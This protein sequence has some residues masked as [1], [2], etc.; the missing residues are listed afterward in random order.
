MHRV[1]NCNW[2]TYVFSSLAA[3]LG[4]ATSAAGHSDIFLTN[5]GEQVAV[6]GANELESATPFFELD[7]QVFEAVLVTGF[8]LPL[9]DYGRGEPGVFALPAGSPDFPAG[10]SA[11]SGTAAVS[12]N[13]PSFTLNGHTDSLFYWDGSGAVD[14]QPIRLSQPGVTLAIDPTPFS[15]PTTSAGALHFHPA[16][17]LVNGGAGVPADGVYLAAPTASVAGMI[18]SKPFYLVLLADQL[19]ADDEAA[20]GLEE[21]F[22]AG[23]TYFEAVGKDFGFYE[24]AVAYVESN[25]AVPEPSTLLLSGISVAAIL[26]L[27]PRRRAS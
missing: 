18:D 20:E 11:L 15:D 3:C 13:L 1:I 22:E 23:E 8:P 12:L 4:L 27:Q 19:L 6:G 7:T 17:E 2:F 9:I 26:S 5:V 14:F 24:E 21:T 16:Y 25:V 10:A